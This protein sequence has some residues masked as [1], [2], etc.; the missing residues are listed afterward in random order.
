MRKLRF[1]HLAGN[2]GLRGPLLNLPAD[3]EVS[4]SGNLLPMRRILAEN[5]T[6]D[7]SRDP[8]S[9]ADPS[10]S[11]PATEK[12]RRRR[13]LVI[14][15]VGFV[16]GG[17]AGVISGVVF[18]ALFR[19]LVNCLRGRYHHRGGPSIFSPLIKPEDLD[20]LSKGDALEGMELIGRG[21]CGEVY[22]TTFTDGKIVAVKKIAKMRLDDG[23]AA[24]ELSEEDSKILDRRMRQIK[25][26]INT[27]GYVRHRNLL[28]L[29]AHVP[30]S[31]C[32]LLVYEFMKNGTLDD[33][34][35]GFAAGHREFDWPAR[36]RVAAGI[37][38]GLEYLHMQH[39]P[40]I[41]HRDLKPANI[42]L[43]D[44]MEARIADFGLAKSV[45]D[46]HTHVTASNVAGTVGFIAP[47]YHQTLKFTD[48]C[49]I[50]SFGVILG[51]MVMGRMPSDEF[52]QSTDELCLVNWLRNAR[53]KGKG[54]EEE[55][56][57]VLKVACLC[58]VNDPR[59]RPNS[60]DVRCMLAQIALLTLPSPS[61][62]PSPSPPPLPSA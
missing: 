25:S 57:L 40:R 28:P 31:E 55:M 29:L 53:L 22:R 23:T 5:S 4:S 6:G 44:E 21:G 9:V 13:P 11:P 16:V 3:K 48:K 7:D 33:A 20:V 34:L 52:F 49:D 58:T 30:R 10:A 56:A 37:A 38:A 32:H 62:S 54:Y 26:E 43:D 17:L 59:E 42:L 1:L 60:K 8:A 51:V 35:K 61:P 36:R 2:P 14:W 50:Y 47:E 27:V 18:S 24:P 12:S 46:A 41:I 45:A 39:S 19:L 15:I